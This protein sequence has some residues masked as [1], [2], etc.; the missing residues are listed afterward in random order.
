MKIAFIGGGS[1]QWTT[2]LLTDM[3]LNETL[4]GAELALHDIDTDA[5]ALATR[6]SERIVE[7]AQSQIRITATA[8]RENALRDARFVILC[9]AIGGLG[10]VRNDLA[11][12]ERYGIYQPVGDTSGP[13]GLAR[14]LRHIPFA[15]QVAREMERLCPNAWLLNLTNPMTTI[16]RGVTRAT[17]IRTVGLCHEVDLFRRHRLAPLFKVPAEVVTVE[18]AGINH[19]PAIVRFSVGNEDG[20]SRLRAWLREHPPSEFV[21]DHVPDPSRD[22]FRDRLAVKLSLFDRLGVLFG[23]GDRHL[24]EFFPS[25][26]SEASGRGAR[27]GVLC[28]TVEHRAENARVRRARLEALAQ[29]GPVELVHSDETLAPVM[30]ALAGGP[31]GR[32]VVN[33]PNVAQIDDLP[34]HVVVESS[35]QVDALGVRPIAVG[36][37]P[38]PLYAALAPHVAWQEL[39][40]EAAL[41]GRREPAR[42]AMAIDPVVHDPAIVDPLLDAL[43][44]ANAPF[45]ESAV[46]GPGRRTAAGRT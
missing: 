4:D 18:V 10:A 17:A 30:A 40:V 24:A 44:A 6:A 21:N 23:A 16:C 19:L 39:V 15:V 14:G 46:G 42:A 41:T 45:V 32:F 29:G 36:V 35:A 33:M 25:F 9:V 43:V 31:T 2:M 7:Q 22:V 38:H 8:D 37:L 11:I 20:A 5:L 34:R 13:G 28:T 27:Y 12:P 1:V 3:V 26:L